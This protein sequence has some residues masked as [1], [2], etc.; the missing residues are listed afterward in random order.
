MDKLLKVIEKNA[1]L[2]LEEI[3][4]II[5]EEPEAAA[6]RLDQYKK[7][8]VIRGTRTLVDWEQVGG[9]DVQAVIEVR[10]TPKRNHGFDKVA[11]AIA[12]LDEVDGVMLMSGG[13]DLHVF[14]S[15]KSFQEVAMF[16]A[17]RLSPI[18]GVLSTATHF[19]LRTYKKDGALYG[20]EERDERMATKL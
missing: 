4:A 14:I 17:R 6:A 12:Q 3:A 19:V 9:G 13:Y 5:G 10:I 7:D 1:R 11:E 2:T 8:G 18:E 16:V 15:G 20:F